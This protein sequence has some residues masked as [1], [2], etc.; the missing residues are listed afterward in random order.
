MMNNKWMKKEE[1]EIL[2]TDLVKT[3]IKSWKLVL[4]WAIICA[5]VFTGFKYYKDTKS[6]AEPH[7]P[8]IEEK[9]LTPLEKEGLA[10]VRSLQNILNE[11]DTYMAESILL[12]I[13]PYQENRTVLEYEVRDE[14]GDTALGILEQYISYIGNGGAVSDVLS[15]NEIDIPV[16][17]LRELIHAEESVSAYDTFNNRPN[18]RFSVYIIGDSAEMAG[19]LADAMEKVL[20]SYRESIFTTPEQELVLLSRQNSIIY[21]IELE[22]KRNSLMSNRNAHTNTINSWVSQFSEMQLAE[23]SGNKNEPENTN[24]K[25]EPVEVK[26]DIKYIIIGIVIGL[27]LGCCWVILCFLLSSK[28]KSAAEIEKNYNVCVYGTVKRT[29]KDGDKNHQEQ[30]WI[31]SRLVLNCHK[32]NIERIVFVSD[33]EL[34]LLLS[35]KDNLLQKRLREHGINSII[36]E[37]MLEQIDIYDKMG[38]TDAVIIF[39][40]AHKTSY[41]FFN[42]ILMLLEENHIFLSGVIVIE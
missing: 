6:I 39:V 34:G 15:Q 29:S 11:Q 41:T 7:Q 25:V 37:N 26:I 21:D 28:I 23:Y 40:N 31:F 27:F 32:N 13:N 9:S 14:N 24:E 42:K 22:Q 12:K 2:I 38:I 35:N 4:C 30:N 19:D 1:R 8:P 36:A 3:V 10:Y 33:H 20:Q 18:R 5:A 17:Y 16:Q